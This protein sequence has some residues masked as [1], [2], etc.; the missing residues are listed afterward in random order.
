MVNYCEDKKEPFFYYKKHDFS[1]SKNSHF[2]KGIKMLSE[3]TMK[4]E[5]FFDLKKH[6]FSK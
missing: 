2:F 4:K 6:N 3:F 5:S 1:Q